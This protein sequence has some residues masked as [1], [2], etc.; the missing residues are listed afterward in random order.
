MRCTVRSR[1]LPELVRPLCPLVE[2]SFATTGVAGWCQNLPQNHSQIQLQSLPH[3]ARPVK[4]ESYKMRKKNGGEGGSFGPG[5]RNVLQDKDISSKPRWAYGS[6]LHAT[7]LHVIPCHSSCPHTTTSR[8]EAGQRDLAIAH[9]SHLRL[10]TPVSPPTP[11]L[12]DGQHGKSAHRDHVS[13]NQW[14]PVPVL[15]PRQGPGDR[16]KRL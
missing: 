7:S 3:F 8:D 4:V 5:G 1:T 16:G 13:Y 2:R 10:L 9:H 12:P 11:V 15:A 6:R 14:Q